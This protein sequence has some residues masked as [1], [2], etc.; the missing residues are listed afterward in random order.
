MYNMV[1]GYS[2]QNFEN[3]KAFAKQYLDIF[4]WKKKLA[5]WKSLSFSFEIRSLKWN[6]RRIL[7]LNYASH[8]LFSIIDIVPAFIMNGHVIPVNQCRGLIEFR[9]SKTRI[10]EKKIDFRNLSN[11]WKLV[12][13]VILS[14]NGE[15]SVSNI[16]GH[17]CC[18]AT[19]CR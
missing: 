15:L 9:I 16:T 17:Y 18:Y 11:I 7:A 1:S 8:V 12:N 3:N 14:R 5:M 10:S 19:K 2:D 6:K 4:I 13:S